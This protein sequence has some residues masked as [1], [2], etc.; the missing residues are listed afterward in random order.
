MLSETNGHVLFWTG[1]S[2]M[3]VASVLYLWKS[4]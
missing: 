2:L 4:F 1:I 3:V